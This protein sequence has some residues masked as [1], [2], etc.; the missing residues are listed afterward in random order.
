MIAGARRALRLAGLTTKAIA[1][2]VARKPQGETTP[3]GVVA[4]AVWKSVVAEGDK[5]RLVMHCEQCRSVAIV[6]ARDGSVKVVMPGALCPVVTAWRELMRATLP[7]AKV[8]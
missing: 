8:R 5:L 1:H 4:A 7:E 2:L 6:N 3:T